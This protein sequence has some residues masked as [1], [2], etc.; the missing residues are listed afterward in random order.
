MGMDSDSNDE[1]KHFKSIPHIYSTSTNLNELRRSVDSIYSFNVDDL[2]RP[3]NK[4][5]GPP[6]LAFDNTKFYW[7]TE[8]WT[9]MA[10]TVF[11][12]RSERWALLIPPNYVCSMNYPLHI[13]KDVQ[14]C[15]LI[16]KGDSNI[17]ARMFM[18]NSPK[19]IEFAYNPVSFIN[20]FP[21]SFGTQIPFH[22]ERSTDLWLHRYR[23]IRYS[24]CDLISTICFICFLIGLL[25]FIGHSW[26]YTGRMFEIETHLEKVS[27]GSCCS[28]YRGT[29]CNMG[30]R[31]GNIPRCIPADDGF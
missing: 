21:E 23:I 31:I 10:S 15:E 3:I 14:Y 18:L 9:H 27:L 29:Y 2:E 30:M 1:W 4:S 20:F 12:F 17:E 5:A 24:M 28:T 13:K 22:I 25:C 8:D 11:F 7:C 16:P 26:G 6:M 19:D